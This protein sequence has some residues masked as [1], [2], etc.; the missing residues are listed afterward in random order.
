M[1]LDELVNTLD[2]FVGVG[3]NQFLKR[4]TDFLSPSLS[5]S[6]GCLIFFLGGYDFFGVLL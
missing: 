3:G 1:K 5:R 4:L 2:D 6:F